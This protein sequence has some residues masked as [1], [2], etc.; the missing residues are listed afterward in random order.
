MCVRCVRGVKR[1]PEMTVR[2]RVG[3]FWLCLSLRGHWTRPECTALRCGKYRHG[4]TSPR[5]TGV[6]VW[7]LAGTFGGDT[8]GD[9]DGASAAPSCGLREVVLARPARVSVVVFASDSPVRLRDG[10]IDLGQEGSGSGG[11]GAWTNIVSGFDSRDMM[12]SETFEAGPGESPASVSV[13][14]DQRVKICSAPH[15]YAYKVN[16]WTLTHAAPTGYKTRR[17]QS[18]SPCSSLS[19][20]PRS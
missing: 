19:P 3:V 12:S 16:S 4:K 5:L 20:G 8:G 2:V 15:A 17:T 11:V 13:M 6:G 7:L 1:M 14:I 9:V 18:Q 10:Y